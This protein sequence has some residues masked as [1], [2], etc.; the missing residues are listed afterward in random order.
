[1][2]K[3]EAGKYAN[4]VC[5]TTTVFKVQN[6]QSRQSNTEIRK[7]EKQKILEIRGATLSRL[8]LFK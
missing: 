8:S 6:H 5:L 4:I 1:M 3:S 7:E 2:S